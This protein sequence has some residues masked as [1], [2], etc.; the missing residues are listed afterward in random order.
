MYEIFSQSKF[1]SRR[2]ELRAKPTTQELKLWLYLKGK[3]LGVKFRRQQGIGPYIADFYC[4]E[5]YLVIELDGSQHFEQKEYDKT[6]DEYFKI[7]GIQTLRF[8]NNE[9]DTNMEGVLMKIRSYL[10]PPSR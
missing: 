5:K 3:N 9:V 10:T 7:F 6:R 2:K 8:W 1:K 4:K